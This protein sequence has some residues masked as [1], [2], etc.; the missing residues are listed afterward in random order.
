MRAVQSMTDT[1]RR[2]RGASREAELWKR[3]RACR[4]I[5][6][7][8]LLLGACLPATAAASEKVRLAAKFTPYHLGADTTLT[9]GFH[10]AS[11]IGELPS[12]LTH[13]AVVLPAGLGFAGSTL[14]LDTCEARVLSQHGPRGCPP[15]AEMGYGTSTFEVPFGSETLRE[16]TYVTTVMAPSTGLHTN[17]LY[18]AEGREPVAAF[19]VFSGELRNGSIGGASGTVVEADVPLVPAAPGGA[20]VSVTRFETTFGPAHLVYYRQVHGRR[21]AYRPKGITVPAKCP[22]RGFPFTASFGFVDG[23]KVIARTAVPCPSAAGRHAHHA[24]RTLALSSPG[25]PR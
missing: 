23:T 7:A 14:G 4:R 3:T 22:R 10:I 2:A 24:S 25:A 8:A 13:V 20:N 5:V 15:D 18:Y 1:T 11:L 16:T 19:V 12:P 21:V 17:L 6:A 9:I